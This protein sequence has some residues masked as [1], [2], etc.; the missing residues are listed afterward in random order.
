MGN[1]SSPQPAHK[2]TQRESVR[3]HVAAFAYSEGEKVQHTLSRHPEDQE[4]DPLI[5]DDGPTDGSLNDS[6]LGRV[7]VLRNETSQRVGAA[8]K[9]VFGYTMNQLRH[10]C[11]SGGERQRLFLMKALSGWRSIMQHFFHSGFTQGYDY[12][13]DYI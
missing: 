4:Y 2:A 9:K 8:M 3:I 12:I 11:Y 1:R 13:N 10:P 6:E 7:V 5:M